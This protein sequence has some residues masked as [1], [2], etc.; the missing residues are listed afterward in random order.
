MGKLCHI[1]GPALRL[2]ALMA[3][4]TMLAACGAEELFGEDRPRVIT[5]NIYAGEICRETGVRSLACFNARQQVKLRCYR[6]I[7]HADCYNQP[8]PYD[9]RRSGRTFI[10]TVD[11]RPYDYGAQPK[12]KPEPEPEFE[13][14]I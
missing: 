10:R 14:P 2:A 3:A 12:K 11:G 1:S 9:V 4:S 13:G 7:G 8:D 5:D 6:T